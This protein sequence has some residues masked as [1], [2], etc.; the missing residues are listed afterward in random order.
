MCRIRFVV[1]FVVAA[2]CAVVV[3]LQAQ[4]GGEQV[5]F[6]VQGSSTTPLL[7]RGPRGPFEGTLT[8]LG[9][10]VYHDGLYH[11]FWND[12]QNGWPP[13]DILIGYATSDN[14]LFFVHQVDQ[15]VFSAEDV[16]YADYVVTVGSVHVEDDGT[17]VMY[18]DTPVTLNVIGRATAPGPKG[19]W[20][21]DPEPA[22]VGDST[23]WD[24]FG[25]ANP[26]VVKTDDGYFMYYAAFGGANN[27]NGHMH[28]GL[29]RSDDGIT[30]TKWNDPSTN[31]PEYAIS[32]PVLG[33]GPAGA[34]DAF[35]AEVPR[36]IRMA[37]GTWV[38]AYRSDDG[39]TS[40]GSRTG[41]GIAT[42][43]DGI[44]WERL[45]SNAVIHE[46]DVPVW[47]TVWG[48]SLLYHDGLFRLYVVAD[49]PPIMG[50]RI[51]LVAYDGAIT[52]SANS[53]GLPDEQRPNLA[54]SYPN[55]FSHET[56]IEYNLDRPSQVSV[57]IFDAVGRRC[58]QIAAEMQPPGAH[59]VVWNGRDET[60]RT[61]A[62]GAYFYVLTVGGKQSVG[63]VLKVI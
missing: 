4:I 1:F 62:P 3:P 58:A 2:Q 29:A 5:K 25:L 21:A 35:K 33:P 57:V 26:S 27:A 14:G 22:L 20:K 32:D 24:R 37:D 41:Y 49:G 45:Q 52:T 12:T 6:K 19:P 60:D 50:T 48:A 59:R 36:V 10:V 47:Y 31:D 56:T 18:F 16:P 44:H 17:W 46:N 8:G 39:S 38:M 55:P 63:K 9:A 28:I 51:H 15:P 7:P 42:S 23:G 40:W 61:L 34:W 13:S 53:D 43:G 54:T 11:M 30:W